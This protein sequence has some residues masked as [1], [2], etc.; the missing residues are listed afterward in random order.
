M[1]HE[2]TNRVGG[3]AAL[4]EIVDFYHEDKNGSS[5][6]PPSIEV[7]DMDEEEE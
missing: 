6:T 4:S 2:T 5:F 7:D 3:G 1:S